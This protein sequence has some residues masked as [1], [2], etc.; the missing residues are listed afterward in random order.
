[1]TIKI[2]LLIDDEGNAKFNTLEDNADNLQVNIA[3]SSLEQLKLKYIG[4]LENDQVMSY[5]IDKNE[6]KPD[7]SDGC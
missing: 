3:I 6:E 5:E 1:M 2:G 7:E 4:K